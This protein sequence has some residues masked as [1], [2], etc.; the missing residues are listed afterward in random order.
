MKKVLSLILLMSLCLFVIACSNDVV[1]ND[2][3]ESDDFAVDNIGEA[4]QVPSSAM[5][6]NRLLYTN[7]SFVDNLEVINLFMGLETNR[8]Y[9]LV[10]LSELFSNENVIRIRENDISRSYEMRFL[11]GRINMVVL[12]GDEFVSTV[13]LEPY[14][15]SW[16][17]NHNV[18][19]PDDFFEIYDSVDD[20][21]DMTREWATT[22]FGTEPR[23][24]FWRINDGFDSNRLVW[25]DGDMWFRFDGPLREY[26]W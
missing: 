24:Y 8:E 4:N 12:V 10:E 13:I 20:V 18:N 22:L 9:T 25:S 1:E 14:S 15:P 17:V 11:W 3:S 6:P 26:G 16:F 23:Y 19:I 2:V 5:D 7:T 21:V